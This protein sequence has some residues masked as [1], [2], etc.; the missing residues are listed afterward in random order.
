MGSRVKTEPSVFVKL[1]E[2]LLLMGYVNV[3]LN[4]YGTGMLAN[5]LQEL[6][7]S[8]WKRRP[9]PGPYRCIYHT[10]VFVCVFVCVCVFMF[11][12][13]SLRPE[14]QSLLC[15]FFMCFVYE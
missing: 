8:Q 10:C 9:R 3:L 13:V 14:S 2:K 11:V 1:Q 15:V 5:V 12:C 7:P 4:T 6:L